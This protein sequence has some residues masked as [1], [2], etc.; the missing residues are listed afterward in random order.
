MSSDD[1]HPFDG[2]FAHLGHHDQHPWV[3]LPWEGVHN[4]VLFSDPVTGFTIELARVEKG[5]AFPQ[6]YHTVM[7]T[8]FLVSGRLRNGDTTIEAG[9][10]NVIPAG[11]LHGPFEAI[12]EAVQFKVFSGVPVYVLADGTTFIY[13]RNGETI[14]A[15]ALDP[16]LITGSNFIAV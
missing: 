8:L 12:E 1:K 5:C 14:A 7:Q 2:F 4:K 6:H 11:E 3:R 13:K 16:S 9:T 15:G 10:F